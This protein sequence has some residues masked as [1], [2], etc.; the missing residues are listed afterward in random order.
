HLPLICFSVTLSTFAHGIGVGWMAPVMR[1]LQTEHS[2]F[3]FA[4]FVEELSWIGSLLGI[5]SVI[6]NLLAGLL[7][8]RIGRKP[9]MYALAVPYVCFWLLSY[10]AQGVEYLYAGRLL[11]GITGGGGYIVLP[12]FISEISDAKIRGRLGSMIMV[13]VNTG[14]LL[15]Y[16]LAANVEY[17]H[18]PFFIIPIPI[19]YFVGNLFLPETPFHLIR[20]GKFEAAEKSFRFYK[21]IDKTDK[22]S[23]LEF[24]EIKQALTQEQAIKDYTLKDFITR[25]A[26]KA[27]TTAMVL[28][29]SNQFTGTF[30]FTTYMSDIFEVSHTTLDVNMSTIVIGAVQIVGTC[31]TILLCDRFGRKVL[32]L[33]SSMGAC[34]C[35]A[36]FGTFIFFAER[37]DLS[38]VGWLPLALLSL[39]IFLCHIGLVGIIFVVIV[40]TM[41]AKIRS[42]AAST[43]IVILSCMVFVT[44]KIFPLCMKYWG[45][46]T[47]MWAASLVGLAG[48]IY[49]ILF[50][51]ETKG[52]SMLD[53]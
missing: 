14:V 1:E 50:F 49:F 38:A 43:I 6:G 8:D 13:S 18:A 23:M 27:Y 48:F 17:F 33:I 4:V 22:N 26:F 21:N 53:P 36:A 41:P 45:L 19:C 31:T 29:L 12:M 32:L 44:L 39:E 46:A 7:Q 40:E 3:S 35:L 15:G 9:V 2:P 30:C 20:A 37:Y 52:K 11:A 42:V 28:V 16:I 51:D 25:P 47:T 34:L 5:G 10:F 24:E